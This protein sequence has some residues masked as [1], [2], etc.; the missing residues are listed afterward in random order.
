MIDSSSTG[1]VGFATLGLEKL[2]PEP[3]T[4]SGVSFSSIIKSLGSAAA[5]G[6]SAVAGAGTIQPLYQDLINKQIEMQQQMQLVS[7][8]SNIEKSKHETQMAAVRNVKAG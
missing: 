7:L 3:R 4:S 1:N 5:S 6:A 8:V 2:L